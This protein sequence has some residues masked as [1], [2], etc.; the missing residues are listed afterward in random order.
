M[1]SILLPTLLFLT[2][3][4]TATAQI[5]SIR[6]D[7][8]QR[9]KTDS[10]GK[11]NE[12]KTQMRSLDIT[13]QNLSRV[14]YDNLVVK[15]WFFT[16]SEKTGKTSVF[17]NGE[18]KTSVAAGKTETLASEQVNSTYTDDHFD[19]TKSKGKNQS[20]SVKKVAGSGE[21]IIGYGARLMDGEKVLQE[22]FSPQGLKEKL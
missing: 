9:Q 8:Q 16:K 11:S 15:Y 18:R 12:T 20:T 1:K 4:F 14:N 17:K 3:A 13:L 7:V 6:M 10:K 21:R 2:A 19:V 5:S 22:V